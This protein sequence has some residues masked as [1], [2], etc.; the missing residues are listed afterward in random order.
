MDLIDNITLFMWYLLLGTGFFYLLFG[1]DDILFDV[2]YWARHLYNKNKHRIYG[3]KRLTVDDLLAVPEK[4]IAIFVGC[5]DEHGVIETM[6]S[7]N[8]ENIH[9]NNYDIFVG[10]YP[11]DLQTIEA[12]KRVALQ[13]PNIHYVVGD[14][15][16]P[17]TKSH[18]LNNIF[19]YIK[20]YEKENK[21]HYDVFVIHDAEDL[22]HPLSLKLYN[23][24]IPRK[25]MV[26]L[27]V[28]PLR[29]PL[30]DFTHWVYNDEFI[31][32]HTKDIIVRE[33][34]KGHVP[35]AGVGTAL[36]RRVM[37]ALEKENRGHPFHD[38]T[39][40]EDYSISLQIHRLNF[41]SIFMTHGIS[42]IVE[43]KRWGFG[44]PIHKEIKQHVV[45]RS[46][47]PSHYFG[48][49]R[50]RS[51]WILGIALQEWR[52]SQWKGGISTKITLFRDRKGL[53]AYFVTGISYLLRIYWIA[54]IFIITP[55]FPNTLTLVN[56]LEMNRWSRYLIIV[57]TILMLNRITQRF[58][59]TTRIYGFMPGLLSI[60]RVYWANI[61]NLH[62]VVL[63]LKIFFLGERKGA[64]SRW[65][66]TKNRFPSYEHRE[67]HKHRLGD[68]LINKGLT[69]VEHLKMALDEQM[70]THKP[71][72]DILLNHKWVEERQLLHILAE[73]HQTGKFNVLKHTI[74]PSDVL[75]PFN[76]QEYAE[77]IKSG[78]LP[79][80]LTH[81]S[82]LVA[83]SEV[84]DDEQQ[85][86]IKQKMHP[87]KVH[88][89]AITPQQKNQLIEKYQQAVKA[90]N[91]Q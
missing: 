70:E 54:H 71:L 81:H 83:S 79:I 7:H 5:W 60:P 45:T 12:V 19:E 46:L 58:I 74:L 27:P 69:S 35:S 76:V 14:K 89:I 8:V 23:Y 57:C 77:L 33:T 31:E 21:K 39:H 16:G 85:Y 73:Q 10:L 64:R 30:W 84:V 88:F 52:H 49:V 59:S 68:L 6:L 1:L 51:R 18:N 55:L 2:I 53:I 48:A 87:L 29:M 28:Y 3:Y 22:I 86:N 62:A 43:K 41:E 17:T 61:I 78:I 24:M 15:P 36:S 72:G 66:K 9:Y 82:L 75:A 32:G 44:K 40:T 42:Q 80:S 65:L 13:F 25:D 37:Y 20:T 47:F 56:L 34:I 90:G 91:T 67:K 4:P 63:S 38:K 11:N 26:Q 50:Q